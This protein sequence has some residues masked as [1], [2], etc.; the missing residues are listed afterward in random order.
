LGSIKYIK[1]AKYGKVDTSLDKMLNSVE[2]GEFR[3][4]DL[5]EVDTWVYG[6]NKKYYTELDVATNKSIAVISGITENNGTNYYTNDTLSKNEIFENELTIS[7]RGEYSGTAF[8]HNHKFVLANNIL[9]MKMPTLTENQKKFMC[10]IINTLPYGGYSGYPKKDTLKDDKIQLPTKNNKIDFNFMEDF[11]TQLENEKIQE[12]EAYLE[13]SDLKDYDLTKEEQKVLE[14]FESGKIKFDNFT[15]KNIFNNIVQG[16]RLTKD[17]QLDG[18]IPFIMAGVTNTGVVN[19]ISNP[20]ASFPKNSITI[21]IF[22]NT[23]YRNYDFGAG[24]DTGVYW[25]DEKQYSKQ[26]MLFLATSMK[27]SLVGKFSYGT[28]LRSSKSFNFKMQLPT[29]NNQP[30]YKLIDTLISAIQ[31]LVIKDVVLYVDKKR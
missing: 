8:Y 12:L 1:R 19:Y 6:K 10:S 17:D 7:T 2:W 15:Y 31:K 30:D 29:K 14:D 24:D 26:T 5:F 3:L 9:V 23:F 22:G 21:D 20:I 16:R 28:K 13:A 25:N 11:I 18:D 27:K 4:G